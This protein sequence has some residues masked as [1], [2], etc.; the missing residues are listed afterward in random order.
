VGSTKKRYKSLAGLCHIPFTFWVHGQLWLERLGADFA[1]WE[2]KRFLWI[3]CLNKLTLKTH[4]VM[5]CSAFQQTSARIAVALSGSFQSNLC[6]WSRSH[7]KTE[8]P[9]VERGWILVL[10][11]H[12]TLPSPLDNVR[13]IHHHYRNKSS[14]HYLNDRKKEDSTF[15]AK[16]SPSWGISVGLFSKHRILLYRLCSE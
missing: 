12:K 16:T 15:R 13:T 2:T 7:W 1:A 14:T 5:F 11:R 10:W 6:N 8:K 4:E 9:F 3:W